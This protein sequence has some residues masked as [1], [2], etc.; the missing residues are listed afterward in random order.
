MGMITGGM[1]NMRNEH[2]IF[3]GTM[4]EK[5]RLRDLGVDGEVILKWILEK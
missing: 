4:K 5:D 3:V 2:K 1:S